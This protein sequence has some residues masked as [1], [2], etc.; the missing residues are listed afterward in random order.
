MAKQF[1]LALAFLALVLSSFFCAPIAHTG[2]A[3]AV[4]NLATAPDWAHLTREQKELLAPLAKNWNTLSEVG[5]RKWLGLSERYA[6]TPAA[7]QEKMRARIYEWASLSK[8]E[9]DNAREQFKKIKPSSAQER[10][11]LEKKWK[12]YEALPAEKKL[13]LKKGASSSAF[14][15]TP[16]EKS[17]A[18]TAPPSHT[19]ESAPQ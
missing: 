18:Q 11:E 17:E 19:T 14:A 7:E 15:I 2:S 5:K 16:A 1:R 10:V 9:R 8:A 4:I 12:Q 6:K 3:T 13:A